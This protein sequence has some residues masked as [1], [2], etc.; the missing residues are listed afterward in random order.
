MTTYE[1]IQK[2]Q[3]TFPGQTVHVAK[4]L[5]FHTHV[6]AKISEEY[7]VSVLEDG[8][9]GDVAIFD[10]ASLEE[11]IAKATAHLTLSVPNE[12]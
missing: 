7:K 8:E 12:E 11:C 6:P 1:A 4:T 5:W 9:F 3:D 10:G 2:L